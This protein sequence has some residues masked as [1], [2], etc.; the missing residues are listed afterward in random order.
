MRFEGEYASVPDIQSCPK[1]E[2]IWITPER[3]IPYLTFIK[4][5]RHL[6]RAAIERPAVFR[7]DK[8]YKKMFEYLFDPI[9]ERF[10]VPADE[11]NYRIIFYLKGISGIIEEWIKNGCKDS[12]EQMVSVICNC[13]STLH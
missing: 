10:S 4:E 1:S 8:T 13:I 12:I 6:Y 5:N 9:L 2:L 3:L 7:S 11:R